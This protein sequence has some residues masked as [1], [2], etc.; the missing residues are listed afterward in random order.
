MGDWLADSKQDAFSSHVTSHVYWRYMKIWFHVLQSVLTCI[1][2]PV[3][4]I[5]SGL[6]YLPCSTSAEV[7]RK[8]EETMK[9]SLCVSIPSAPSKSKSHDERGCIDNPF[10]LLPLLR[11]SFVQ[12]QQS[13]HAT[14]GVGVDIVRS[15]RRRDGLHPGLLL[16]ASSCNLHSCP[17]TLN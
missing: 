12:S 6:P 3:R 10:Q 5:F 8:A 4:S 16:F 9:P 7:E 17:L 14:S 2:R 11:Q 1:C 15:C 13:H